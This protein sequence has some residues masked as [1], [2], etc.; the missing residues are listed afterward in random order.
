MAKLHGLLVNLD[1]C[2]GCY[3]CEVACKQENNVPTGTKWINVVTV[4]PEELYGSLSMDFVPVM[5][6]ACTLCDHRLR[7][8]RKPS[9]VDNCPTSALVY[10]G[11][12]RRILAILRNGKRFQICKLKGEAPAFG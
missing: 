3:A 12:P 5:T 1:I 11:S 4:G 8:N 7:K 6:E 10:C 9:C 2:V